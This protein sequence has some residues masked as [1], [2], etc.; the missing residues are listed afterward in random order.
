MFAAMA[1]L[2]LSLA[3]C[4]DD[5]LSSDDQDQITHTIEFAATSGD[6]KAC[7]EAQ[8]QNFTEQ[9]TGQTGEAA[10][11]QCEEDAQPPTAD[12]VEVSNFDGDNDSATADAAFKGE[13]FDGQTV[14]VALV[15]EGDQWKLDKAVGFKD[16]DRDAFL[17]TFPQSL[18]STGAPAAAI[19][20]VSK[21]L[22]DLSDQEIE[23]LF[24]YSDPQLQH[25]VFDPCFRGE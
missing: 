14:Q 10:V 19:D 17:T 12:S 20:C 16:F 15:K 9:T 11:K 2:P 13:F 24:L 6:P 4:G 23:D 22:Q 21:N 25:Q 3:A 1:A 8:T 5:G 7:T 18:A